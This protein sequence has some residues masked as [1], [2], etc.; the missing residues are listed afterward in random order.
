MESQDIAILNAI[1]IRD[2]DLYNKFFDKSELVDC[3][4]NSL[5]RDRLKVLFQE[6]GGQGNFDTFIIRVLETKKQN[7][8]LIESFPTNDICGNSSTIT[9]P[10][11]ICKN[12][13]VGRSIQ[14]TSDLKESPPNKDICKNSSKIT[15]PQYMIDICK[16]QTVDRLA[17]FD[18]LRFITCKISKKD[19][20]FLEFQS[21]NDT[22]DKLL[23][24]TK[25]YST[26]NHFKKIAR[27]IEILNKIYKFKILEPHYK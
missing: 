9:K 20:I 1:Q 3:D 19:Y 25:R 23:Y 4:L 14:E 2:N 6:C 21:D 13:T 18:P 24:R 11:Y 12:Q 27:K 15:K 5:T 22:F 8:D 17:Q 26:N 16:N 10:Q 7:S